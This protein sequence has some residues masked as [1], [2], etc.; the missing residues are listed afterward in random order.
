MNGLT[1][2]ELIKLSVPMEDFDSE[3]EESEEYDES[4]EF[5]QSENSL[6]IPPLWLESPSD[7]ESLRDSTPMPM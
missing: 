6:E 5:E 7:Q 3:E 1:E 2:E 4:M